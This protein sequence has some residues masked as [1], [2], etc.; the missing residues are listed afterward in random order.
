[1][2]IIAAAN[3]VTLRLR[4]RYLTCPQGHPYSDPAIRYSTPEGHWHC[5][6]CMNEAQ[7]RHIARRNG[8]D[9]PLLPPGPRRRT[10]A[11]A[12]ASPVA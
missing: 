5:R 9:V 3:W 11:A 4:H 12:T 2:A 8:L 10:S 6:P 1:M 7:K